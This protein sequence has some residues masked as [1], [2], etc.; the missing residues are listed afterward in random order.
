MIEDSQRL[1][2]CLSEMRTGQKQLRDSLERAE[3]EQREI[4]LMLS[5]YNVCLLNHLFLPN[6]TF[7]G[8]NVNLLRH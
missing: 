2:I 3:R 5:V 8:E 4:E 6:M 1:D 7:R